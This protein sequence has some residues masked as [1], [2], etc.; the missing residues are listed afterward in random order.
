[1][2][3]LIPSTMPSEDLEALKEQMRKEAR[4]IAAETFEQK[5]KELRWSSFDIPKH[6]HNGKDS[7]SISQADVIPGRSAI[8]SLTMENNQ[9]YKLGLTF[10]PTQLLLFGVAVGPN[11]ERVQIASS[12]RF[13]TSYYFQPESTSSVT[14]GGPEYNVVQGGSWLWTDNGT[15][16]FRS[17]AVEGHL[18]N[19]DDVGET[20]VVRATIPNLSTQASLVYGNN[21]GPVTNNYGD[22]ST[23]GYGNGYV[24]V[25]VTLSS[26]WSITATFIVS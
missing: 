19:I 8:G 16:T 2:V 17:R 14:Q 21:P 15:T 23:K 22:R 1:M 7:P 24:Y 6:T 3:T 12:A 20:I 25:D 11:G 26:G 5:A 10:N 18:T 13:G 9:R 4:D